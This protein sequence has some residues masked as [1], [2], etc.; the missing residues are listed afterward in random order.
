MSAV[1]KLLLL[2]V[3]RLFV[4]NA[5]QNVLEFVYQCD[6]THHKQTNKQNVKLELL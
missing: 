2:R 1:L 6:Y 5:F 4:K 3:R